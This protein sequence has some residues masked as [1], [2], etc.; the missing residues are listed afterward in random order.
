[1]HVYWYFIFIFMILYFILYFHKVAGN[2][3][4]V[5]EHWRFVSG[6]ST[7]SLWSHLLRSHLFCLRLVSPHFFFFIIFT[8]AFY[9]LL[10]WLFLYNTPK[11]CMS[12]CFCVVTLLCTVHIVTYHILLHTI[13][14]FLVGYFRCWVCFFIFFSFVFLA[15]FLLLNFFF[16]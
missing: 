12:C 5:E 4:I 2:C 6:N 14:L 16:Y 7:I 8:F 1:M 13:I 9:L 15:A 11:I 10:L 3:K